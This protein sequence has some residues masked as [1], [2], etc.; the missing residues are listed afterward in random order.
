VMDK[1]KI[2]Q[3]LFGNF[4]KCLYPLQKFDSDTERRFAVILERDAQKWFKP[5]KGQFKIYYQ[6]GTEHPEY[7]PDFIVELE[8][9]VLMVETKAQK[10]MQNSTVLTKADAAVKWCEHASTHLLANGGKEWVYLLVPH[11]DVK[12]NLKITDYLNR[13]RFQETI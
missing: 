3:M 8:D 10:E 4:S 5:A 12:E 13:F 11:D 9:C 2:K 7:V 1:S 6:D